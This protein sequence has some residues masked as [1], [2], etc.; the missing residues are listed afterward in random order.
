[1][2][3]AKNLNRFYRYC[4][5][6]TAERQSAYDLLQSALEKYLA[7]P[8]SIPESAEG[9]LFSI[10]RNTFIDQY[11]RQKLLPMEPFDEDTNHVDIDVLTLEQ[12][13]IQ[14]DQIVS[15]LRLLDPFERE[16]LFLW[17]VEGYTVD[18]LSDRL[19]T[20]RGTILS[21]IYRLRRKVKQNMRSEAG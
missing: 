16:I 18:E 12:L 19:E 20:P 2:F 9:F 5:S 7:S 3:D 21:R 14:H 1:M 6:L 17:A 11:R 13:A 4:Y 8:P 15:I 10:I